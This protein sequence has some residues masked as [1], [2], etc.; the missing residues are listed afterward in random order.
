MELGR[1]G[2]TFPQE[3]QLLILLLRLV[4]QPFAREPSQLPYPGLHVIPQLPE[5]H[6]GLELGCEE[7]A[8]PHEPQLLTLVLRLVS[9]PFAGLLSQLPL[10]EAQLVQLFTLQ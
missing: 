4:S 7:H 1:E 8:F 9:Q 3:P 10:P 5:V 6:A 2:Q